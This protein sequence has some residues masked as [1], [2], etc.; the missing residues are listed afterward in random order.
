MDLSIII[1]NY[2]SKG[3]ALNC[4]KSIKEADLAGLEYEIIVVDNHSQDNIGEILSWQFPDV[5]FIQNEKNI[6]YGPGNNLGL[7]RAQGEYFVIMNPDTIAF[8]QTFKTLYKF[9]NDNPQVGV[10]GPKQ[11][12]PD[13]TV[14]ESCYRWHSLLT[15]FYR[16]TVLGNF[17]FAKRDLDRFL[18]TDFDKQSISDVDWLLGSFLF[19][20]AKAMKEIGYYDKRYFL[21][22]EDT[23]LCRQMWQKN[24]QVVYNP[25]AEVIHNHNRASAKTPLYKFFTSP[26]ARAHISSWIKYL[27]KWG[28]KSELKK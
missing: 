10:C 2:K 20:R 15:P 3:L 6:G 8:P 19:L 23:D 14:Q 27:I 28:L 22:F 16:R 24:W 7:A 26:S 11:Y 1:L 4:I 9:M 18:M 12:N 5:K 25:M 13:R 17:Q 21:Y